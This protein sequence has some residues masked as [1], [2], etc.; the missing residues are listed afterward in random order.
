MSTKVVLD[1]MDHPVDAR[2]GDERRLG[3]EALLLL[4]S[5][6]LSQFEF[7]KFTGEVRDVGSVSLFS[8]LTNRMPGNQML[9]Y[10]RA[11]LVV[12]DYFLLTLFLKLHNLAQLLCHFCP[13]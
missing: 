12:R 2:E 9:L 11:T 6:L 7:R 4:V 8:M 3:H 13:I 1:Q 5:L 10:Y